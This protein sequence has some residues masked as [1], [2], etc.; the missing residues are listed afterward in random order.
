MKKNLF[1]SVL[2]ILFI[3]LSG[4]SKPPVMADRVLVKNDSDWKVTAVKVQHIPT[5]RI[6]AVS[7]ILPQESLDIGFPKQ[8]LLADRAIIRWVD[9]Q[10]QNRSDELEIPYD[11]TAARAERTMS[12]TYILLP[13]GSVIA[14]LQDSSLLNY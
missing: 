8:P 9:G 13:S 1:V 4:C 11:A 3:A 2:F 7:A 12:L 14:H 6:G 5:N 10:G